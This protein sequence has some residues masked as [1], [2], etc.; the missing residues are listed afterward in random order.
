MVL[1][2]ASTRLLYVCFFITRNTVF[3]RFIA[4]IIRLNAQFPDY[5][6]KKVRLDNAGEFTSQAFNDYCVSMRIDIKYP[7]PHVHTQN[8][9]AELLIKRLQLIA[10][11]LILR[12]KLPIS[13]WGDMLYY[14]L[15]I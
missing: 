8:N 10:K 4:Q 1:I 5:A 6:I 12:T 2:N 15:R 9:M 11:P 14:T 7:V 3:A 13:I